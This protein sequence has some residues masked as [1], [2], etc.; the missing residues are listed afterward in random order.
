MN[1]QTYEKLNIGIVGAR[2]HLG[3]RVYPDFLTPARLTVTFWTAAMAGRGTL[4]RR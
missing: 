2:T 4:H 1:K 3:I